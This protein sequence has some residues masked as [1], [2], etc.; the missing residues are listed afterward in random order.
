M[1]PL[2]I[3]HDRVGK[4]YVAENLQISL[5]HTRGAAAAALCKSNVGVDLEQIRILRAGMAQRVMSPMEYSWYKSRGAKK[6]D[7]FTL[8]TLKESYYKYLGTGL[9]GIPNRTNFC[10]QNG[11]WH[12]EGQK[13][14]FFVWQT[15][16]LSIALCC[17]EQE[18]CVMQFPEN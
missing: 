13:Q 2:P 1:E 14:K 15:E 10:L 8:W 9:R 5:S 6:E 3:L 17:E 18:V 12:L 7:F 4:P 16:T 11:I